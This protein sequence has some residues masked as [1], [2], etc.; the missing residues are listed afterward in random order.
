MTIKE[1]EQRSGM[2][3][4]NIRYYEQEGLLN[5]RR[6]DN[7]YRDYTGADLETLLRIRL[8]RSLTVSLEEL[9]ALQSGQAQLSDTLTQ[10]LGEL[11]R[12]ARSLAFAQDICRAMREDGVTYPTLNA[13]KY[14]EQLPPSASVPRRLEAAP[15]TRSQVFYPWRRF[16]ARE[17]DIVTYSVA[18]SAALALLFRVNLSM[19]TGVFRL[20]DVF[21]TTA[22]MLFV[23]PLL[24][25]LFGTTLGKW[26]FGLRLEDEN[27]GRPSYTAA[28]ERTGG[29]LSVGLGLHIPIFNLYRLWKSYELCVDRQ[30]QPWDNALVYTSK[31]TKAYRWAVFVGVCALLFGVLWTADLAAQRPPNH[32]DLTVAQ[33]AENYNAL[34]SFYG[35][36][37]A[38]FLNSEGQWETRSDT[39]VII[40]PTDTPLPSFRYA[41]EDGHLTGV[42]LELKAAHTRGW[43]TYPG[44]ITVVSALAFAGAQREAGLFSGVRPE[45]LRELSDRGF[46]SFSFDKVGV[47]IACE[48]DYSGYRVPGSKPTY[49]LPLEGAETRLYMLFSM[50]KLTEKN[51]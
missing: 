41:V 40:L 10:K 26:V 34:A 50:D 13:S 21:V 23:E 7:G 18:W 22:L 33:F 51:R 19:R 46:E 25:R 6:A 1:A 45:L 4:A 27:G 29:V 16:L 15:D 47:H 14:L 2:T 32:G 35:V 20:L 9:R 28:L 36:E 11:E 30:P 37:D 5:P 42:S 43:L 39:A 48:V 12:E 24:L 8:L 44:N 31:D 49:L 17:L 3:R 38:R